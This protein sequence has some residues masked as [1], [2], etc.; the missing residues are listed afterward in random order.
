MTRPDVLALVSLRE[1][2]L[3]IIGDRYTIHDGAGDAGTATRER[4]RPEVRAVLT[5]GSTGY[6]D[7]DMAATPRL[8]LVCVSGAGLDNIDLAAAARR[9]IL[10]ANTSGANAPSVAD[11]A[12]GLM[13]ALARRIPGYDR[14]VRDGGWKD[15]R[16]APPGQISGRRLGIIGLGHIGERIARRATAFDMR[17][18]Y[19][20][21]RRRTDVPYEWHDSSVG[22]AGTSDF[23][24]V[25]AAKGPTSTGIVGRA[26][27]DALGAGGFLINV[28]RGDLVVTEELIAALREGRIAG[29][30]LDVFDDEPRVPAALRDLPNTVLTPHVGGQSPESVR[31]RCERILANLDAYFTHGTAATPVRPS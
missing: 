20:N 12:L 16:G 29:A 17:V 23:L 9:G 31:A 11:H 24:V 28:S 10:V 4:L 21:R 26:V 18:G 13:L 7:A 5:N 27:L 6:T 3:A 2:E 19:L 30:G 1:R 14:L 22:L 25:S 15:R 8:G